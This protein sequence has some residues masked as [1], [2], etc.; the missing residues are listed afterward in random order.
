MR[1]VVPVK[2]VAS[3]DEDADL[4]GGTVDPADLE[5][6]LNEWDEF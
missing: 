4:R 1:I 6:D 5:W 2:H 3:I